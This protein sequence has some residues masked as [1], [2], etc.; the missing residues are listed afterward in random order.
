MAV[1]GVP[2]LP[3]LSVIRPLLLPP[4]PALRPRLSFPLPSPPASDAEPPAGSLEAGEGDA[5]AR[6][7]SEVSIGQWG[8]EKEAVESVDARE[9]S[10]DS[11]GAWRRRAA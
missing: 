11:R 4:S 1:L 10:K 5:L 9:R 2:L 6:G 7:G 3:C 8:E